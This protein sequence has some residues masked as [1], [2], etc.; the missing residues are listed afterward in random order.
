[1]ST[2]SAKPEPQL[3]RLTDLGVHRPGQ[4]PLLLPRHW[5]DLRAPIER[6][7]FDPGQQGQRVLVRG[8][9]RYPAQ[10]HF[11]PG[12]PP[13]MTAT[14]EDGEGIWLRVS[15][16]GDTRRLEAQ[17]PSAGEP[18]TIF[19]RLR[20][21]KDRP[22]LS[23]I[24]LPDPRWIGRLRPVYPGKT[25][26][27]RPDTVRSRIAE[28]FR[29]CLP[30]AVN[31]IG[32]R[33]PLTER[34]WEHLLADWPDLT[35]VLIQA[36]YPQSVE[37]G[38]QAHKVL[39]KFAAIE[40][41]QTARDARPAGKAR[42]WSNLD[43]ETETAR[44]P[45]DLTQEQFTAVNAIIEDLGKP[46][47]MRRILTGDVGTGKTPVYLIPAV[48]AMKAGAR[49]AILAPSEPLAGQIHERVTGFW[50]ELA[51]Q[52]HKVTG[53][54]PA[55][56]NEPV[57]AVGTTRLLHH[58]GGEFDF[59]IVDEQQKFSRNQREFFT[60]NAHL[61]EATATCIP[62]TQ[63]L[64]E[65][66]VFSVS[67]LRHAHVERQIQ[68]RLWDDGSKA[69]LFTEIREAIDRGEKILAIYPRKERGDRGVFDL[70]RAREN[71]EQICP[72]RVRV[73]HSDIEDEQVRQALADL[74]EGRASVLVAT[75]VLEVGIDLPDLRRLVVSHAERFGLTTLHQLR[76]RLA[77]AGG[78]GRCDLVVPAS[79][80]EDSRERL[81]T[82]TQ[83][84]DGFEIAHADLR[85]RGFGDLA[86]ASEAQT[87]HQDGLL[88]GRPLDYDDLEEGA[89]VFMNKAD[90][91]IF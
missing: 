19:G 41:L 55:P 76:G 67:Q 82:L 78:E 85:Q 45:F 51:D 25:K 38:E 80:G 77:R 22:Q 90:E 72:G 2:Q 8:V 47:P 60:M 61:L 86:Q 64:A 54:A 83:T 58:P 65:Q 48:C 89:G 13:R 66:G 1:M 34:Q 62:R 30:E 29:L 3:G 57:I 71:W 91:D 87:G 17:F 11:D 21:W 42:A 14:I 18:V 68:T 56:P 16:F 88:P 63:A 49:V 40:A 33:L 27:I 69:E 24:E 35:T 7:R 6:F 75:T 23:D 81:E 26:R 9:C 79:L 37:R 53:Q 5:E 12:K 28:N 32:E 84:N 46:E 73:A 20:F 74:T 4:L 44:L 52:C 15:A 31:E 50:P 70:E 39:H 10:T 43:A 36:H 59:V